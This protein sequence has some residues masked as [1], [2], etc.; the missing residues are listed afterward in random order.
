MAE[1]IGLAASIV[2]IV[3]MG[4]K[5]AFTLQTYVGAVAEAEQRLGEVAQNVNSIAAALKQ[6]AIIVDADQLR[7]G[8]SQSSVA[9][10]T[11]VFNEC[12]RIEVKKLASRCEIIYTA[13]ITLIMK[14]ADPNTNMSKIGNSALPLKASIITNLT[15]TRRL[16]WPW[17]EP[18]ITECEKRL[19]WLKIDLMFHLHVASIAQYQLRYDLHMHNP[20]FPIEPSHNSAL[21]T[22][23]SA[24]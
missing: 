20:L 13:I 10:N 16:R 21:L 17:L 9:A 2:G 11:S 18:R 4:F 7:D 22:T 15:W 23:T 5:L 12:G 6:L 24:L 3:D 14:S 1:V 19:Q 8:D